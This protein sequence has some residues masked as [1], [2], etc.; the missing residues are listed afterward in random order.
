MT[1]FL[2]DCIV[3]RLLVRLL[4]RLQGTK[5]NGGSLIVVLL[6]CCCSYGLLA[7]CMPS[8]PRSVS[9]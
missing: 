2:S 5:R 8:I 9:R 6:C 4:F 1:P 3:S 7:F